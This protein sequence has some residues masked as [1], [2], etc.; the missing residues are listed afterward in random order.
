MGQLRTS[1]LVVFSCA[2]MTVQA[3]NFNVKTAPIVS[4]TI[5]FLIPQDVLKNFGKASDR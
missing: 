2:V 1:L 4:E 3:A 5:N